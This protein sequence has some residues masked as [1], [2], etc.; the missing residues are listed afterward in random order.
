MLTDCQWQCGCQCVS[1]S[2][3]FANPK[4][5]VPIV[6]CHLRKSL[7]ADRFPE[8]SVG[9]GVQL[10]DYCQNQPCFLPIIRRFACFAAHFCQ[11]GLILTAICS[12]FPAGNGKVAADR[13]IPLPLP[14]KVPICVLALLPITPELAVTQMKTPTFVLLPLLDCEEKAT[15]ILSE[16]IKRMVTPFCNRRST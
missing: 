12:Q 14:S 13:M 9:H 6:V 7:L 8:M 4:P 3:F 2:D 11:F 10:P 1:C 15:L 16:T 5:S